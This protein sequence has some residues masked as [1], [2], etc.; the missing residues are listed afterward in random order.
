MKMKYDSFRPVFAINSTKILRKIVYFLKIKIIRPVSKAIA[1]K[2]VRNAIFYLNS[3]ILTK[4][5][6]L[7]HYSCN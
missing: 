2:L 6:L 7:G 5:R 1:F 4:A 3:L